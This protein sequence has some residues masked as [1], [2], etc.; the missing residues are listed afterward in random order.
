M[1]KKTYAQNLLTYKNSQ[2]EIVAELGVELV[3][4]AGRGSSSQRGYTHQLAMG[5]AKAHCG[6]EERCY[7]FS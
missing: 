2:C 4:S 1:D 5:C 6:L 7:S 3:F